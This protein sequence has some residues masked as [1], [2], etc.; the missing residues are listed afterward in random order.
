MVQQ[1]L[2]QKKRIF[3]IINMQKIYGWHG[4][5]LMNINSYRVFLEAVRLGNLTAAAESFGYTQS[6]V[7]HIVSQLEEEFGFPLMFRGKN[8]VKLTKDGENIA[9][10]MREVVNRDD[11][12]HQVAAEI[13]GLQSGTVRIGAIESVAMHKLPALIK[14]FTALHPNIRFE[15]T[16]GDYEI[17]ENLLVSEVID[18]GFISSTI[19]KKL[20]FTPLMQDELVAL[21]PYSHPLSNE[22]SLT[23]ETISKLD[24]IVPGEGTNYDIGRIF[25]QAG[26]KLN[27]RM[28]VNYD[29]VAIA[30]VNCGL[31]VTI[32]PNLILSGISDCGRAIP[33]SPR[34][35]RTI[36]FATNGTSPVSPACRAFLKFVR[37]RIGEELPPE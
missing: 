12:L 21:L 13:T 35:F 2:L 11:R 26:I 3:V 23:L 36:G 8:G 24:F 32:M 9:L 22:K 29:Y 19:T 33:L 15:T 28:A 10:L 25:K 5:F 16:V 37:E 31:G 14:E 27:V 7:S 20:H 6:G 18:C 17:V 4:V 34:C 1:K 30:M